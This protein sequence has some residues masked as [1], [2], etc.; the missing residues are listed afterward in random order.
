V[1]TNFDKASVAK[2]AYSVKDAGAEYDIATVYNGDPNTFVTATK[3][4]LCI[5]YTN[6]ALYQNT[7]GST[8][9]T[10]ISALSGNLP[11]LLLRKNG[12]QSL[13]AGFN[14]VTGFTVDKDTHTG[15]SSN[16]YYFPYD[17]EYL[18]IANAIS[19]NLAGYRIN[20]G[21]DRWIGSDNH[22]G[23]DSVSGGSKIISV[24]AGDYLEFVVSNASPG[25]LFA[26]DQYTYFSIFKFP[27]SNFVST[28]TSVKVRYS[29]TAGQSIPDSTQTIV[30]FDTVTFDAG[31][32]VTT[33]ASWKFTA[34]ETASYRISIFISWSQS[35]SFT[36]GQYTQA[37][38][39]K[40]GTFYSTLDISQAFLTGTQY[41]TLNGS[42]SINLTSGDYIDVR[43][44]QNTGSSVN[45]DTSAGSNYICIEKTGT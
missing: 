10:N 19:I 27:A 1:A 4:A 2:E 32:L 3:G 22:G 28:V 42:D 26:D 34:S 29:T 39:Y 31:S 30:D 5:D 9:W 6:G 16:K 41:L 38:L 17:G 40:N 20:G 36:T 24:N 13:S 21:S 12:N 18:V 35:F 43:V 37:S 7:N 33:G 15:F 45:L 44:Y 11:Q 23:S 14:V 8:A 25:T